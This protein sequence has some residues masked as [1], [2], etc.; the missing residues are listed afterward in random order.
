[1]ATGVQSRLPSDAGRWL[2]R[3]L[4]MRD[5]V[6]LAAL[7]EVLDGAACYYTFLVDDR[8]RAEMLARELVAH[9]DALGDSY[10]ACDGHNYLAS[11]AMRRSDYPEA[12]AHC[13]QTLALA[14]NARN[15]ATQIAWAVFGLARVALHQ[16]DLTAAATGFA[17]ALA[18]NREIGYLYGTQVALIHM[19]R[20]RLA[21][22]DFKEAAA[23]FA[24]GMGLACE[25]RETSGI[26]DGL[27]RLALVAATMGQVQHAAHLLGAVDALRLRY[28]VLHDLESTAEA[29]QAEVGARRTMG[30]EHFAEEWESG[31]NMSMEGAIQEA[32]A[33]AEMAQAGFRPKAGTA[34]HDLTPREIAVLCL[35]VEG[36]SDKEIAETLGTTRRTASKHVETIRGKFGVSTR[37]AAAAYATRHGMV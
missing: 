7:T 8:A 32:Y 27:V 31:H 37:T 2:E 22:G 5:D 16:G 19:G 30:D 11:L 36:L 15:S 4:A 21:Q 9:A 26:A 13:R 33:V 20:V 1:V 6:S 35:L 25:S 18:R 10:A 34:G 3:A 23:Q 14:P 24:E 12:I 28:G 29:V 17:D